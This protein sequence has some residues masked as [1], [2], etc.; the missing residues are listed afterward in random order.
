MACLP[1]LLLG[2]VAGSPGC[3]P[4][5]VV[6]PNSFGGSCCRGFWAAGR[7]T[8]VARKCN[9]RHC[10]RSPYEVRCNVASTSFHQQTWNGP[11]PHMHYAAARLFRRM[12]TS[13]ARST[14]APLA[15]LGKALKPPTAPPG[16]CS[17]GRVHLQVHRLRDERH[18][19]VLA[20][21]AWVRE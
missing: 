7:C 4:G 20:P 19:R 1:C 14:Q 18:V 15:A 13:K 12:S 8:C 21:A 5:Q 6:P 16:Q 11:A 17:H 9:N 3:N 2:L 10:I